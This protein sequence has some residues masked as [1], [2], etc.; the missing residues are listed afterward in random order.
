MKEEKRGERGRGIFCPT[1]HSIIMKVK[2]WLQKR[3]KTLV[4]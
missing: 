1:I 2:K 3:K 4:N